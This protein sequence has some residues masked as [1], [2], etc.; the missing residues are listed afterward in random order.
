MSLHLT[1]KLELS[2]HIDPNLLPEQAREELVQ[3]VSGPTDVYRRKL[4]DPAIGKR[5]LLASIETLTME[6]FLETLHNLTATDLQEISIDSYG[7]TASQLDHTDIGNIDC[8]DGE[9]DDH[10]FIGL[11]ESEPN[12]T[13][14]W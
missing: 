9:N 4:Q 14:F 11:A 10:P 2:F 7:I 5:L 3:L 12:A 6:R 1:V 13:Y 8:D